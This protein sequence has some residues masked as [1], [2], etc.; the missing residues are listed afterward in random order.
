M[1]ALGA[2]VERMADLVCSFKLTVV[3]IVLG[4]ISHRERLDCWLYLKEV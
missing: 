1:K 4:A 2:I 3:K